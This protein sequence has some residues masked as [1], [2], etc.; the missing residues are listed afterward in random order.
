MSY[1]VKPG[2]HAIITNS[3]HGKD[4]PSVGR[5]VLVHADAPLGNSE[6]DNAYVDTNNARNDPHHYCPPSPYEKEHTQLGKI[7]PVTDLAGKPFTDVN[8]NTRQFGEVPDRWLEKALTPPP[9]AIDTGIP[10]DLLSHK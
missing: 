1:N 4:G 2:D 7:W 8:G 10:E 6:A 5:R 9:V 3:V